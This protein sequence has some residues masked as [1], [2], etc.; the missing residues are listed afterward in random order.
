MDA[1]G[2][3]V[4]AHLRCCGGLAALLADRPAGLPCVWE[5]ARPVT[6]LRQPLS[7]LYRV[8]RGGPLQQ[9]PRLRRRRP[10][11]IVAGGCGVAGVA[12]GLPVQQSGGDDIRIR[13]T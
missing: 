3:A 11:R 8:L 2:L 6:H 7:E 5:A 1:Q 4:R 9:Q 10:R 13:A 12:R